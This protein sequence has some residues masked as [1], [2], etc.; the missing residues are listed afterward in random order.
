MVDKIEIKREKNR[1]RNYSL[2]S[3]SPKLAYCGVLTTD[4]LLTLRSFYYAAKFKM[5]NEIFASIFFDILACIRI[6]CNN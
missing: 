3:Y 2:S 1:E 5:I 6:F 4:G